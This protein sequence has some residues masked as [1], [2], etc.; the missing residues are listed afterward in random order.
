MACSRQIEVGCVSANHNLYYQSPV[1]EQ[2]HTC[3]GFHQRYKG[4]FSPQFV[5]TF[6]ST[7][8]EKHLLQIAHST[9]M[10]SITATYQ[11]DLSYLGHLHLLSKLYINEPKDRSRHHLKRDICTL[12]H[13]CIIWYRQ[14]INF[15]NHITH[16][17]YLSDDHSSKY[18]VHFME[19]D[20]C[21][22]YSSSVVKYK[23]SCW[24][25]ATH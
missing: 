14:V 13:A 6:I 21:M 9:L 4:R 19:R 12:N 10:C 7:T 18:H 24:D 23:S 22:H 3:H 11:S 20:N 2:C 8:G 1:V 5:I 17:E 15:F 16:R 25:V